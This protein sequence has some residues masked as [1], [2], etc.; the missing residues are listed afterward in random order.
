MMQPIMMMIADPNGGPPKQ[1]M[2][3]PVQGQEPGTIVYMPVANPQ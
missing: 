1:V 3:M 2:M